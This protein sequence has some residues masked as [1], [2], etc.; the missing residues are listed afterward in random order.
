MNAHPALVRP[1][2]GLRP[3]A[4]VTL[5]APPTQPPGLLEL[6]FKHWVAAHRDGLFRW[7]MLR[8]AEPGRRRS[9]AATA[10]TIQRLRGVE[11][12]DTWLFGAAVQAAAS[13]QVLPGGLPEAA[14]AGLAPELRTLLRLVSRGDLRAEEA[15]AFF[16]QPLVKVRCRLLQAR[17]EPA[18]QRH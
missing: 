13:A 17:M 7:T 8:V 14:L 4:L 3:L 16:T 2:A 10:V 12:M 18:R 1:G 9:F 5:E 6:P 15:K 11:G